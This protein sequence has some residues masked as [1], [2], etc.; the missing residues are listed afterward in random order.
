M[1]KIGIGIVALMVSVMT[2]LSDATVIATV[3]LAALISSHPKTEENKKVL[4]SLKS[5]AEAS[6]DKKIESLKKL[7]DEVT[8]AIASAENEALNEAARMAAR[9]NAKMKARQ[10]QSD[11]AALRDFVSDLQKQLSSAE[12]AC[13]RETVDD[14]QAAVD[15]VAQEKGVGLV[16]DSSKNPIGGYSPVVFSAKELDLT[17]AVAEKLVSIVTSRAASAKK[18]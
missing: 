2:G 4:E 18:E 12:M 10:I 6:R 8:A 9:E 16:L 17:P 7:R 3:D 1:K 11:E 15:A 13:L 14:I 5:E